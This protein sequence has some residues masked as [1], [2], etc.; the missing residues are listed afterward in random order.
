MDREVAADAAIGEPADAERGDHRAAGLPGAG[1]PFHAVGHVVLRVGCRRGRFAAAF[2]ARGLMQRHRADQQR[3]AQAHARGHQHR[4]LRA[5]RQVVVPAPFHLQRRTGLR[6][7]PL[8]HA[9]GE[10]LLELLAQEPE[11]RAAQRQCAG[12]V[13]RH[14]GGD[15]LQADRMR[16]VR[17]AGIARRV[18]QVVKGQRC[19]QRLAGQLLQAFMQ[20]LGQCRFTCI[21]TEATAQAQQVAPGHTRY[22]QRGSG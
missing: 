2:A 17:L 5:L 21:A 18:V 9:G 14:A 15:H 8:H 22:A 1:Q 19:I 13:V 7:Q 16:A 4:Q 3:E 20:P 10:Q 6:H 11:L 12:F